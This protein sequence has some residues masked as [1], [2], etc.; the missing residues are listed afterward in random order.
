[1]VGHVVSPAT[2]GLPCYLVALPDI[3]S[4]DAVLDA[5]D[6]FEELGAP[7]F[8]ER[9]GSGLGATMTI[10]Y[11]GRSY[12]ALPVLNAAHEEL[13][14]SPLAPDQLGEH[15]A[16]DR[17]QALGFRV[18]GVSASP[19]GRRASSS[20]GST[21]KKPAATR[22][23]GSRAPSRA[24]AARVILLEW[25]VEPGEL[26]TRQELAQTFGVSKHATVDIS[27]RSRSVLAFLSPQNGLAHRTEGGAYLVTGDGRRGNQVWNSAN[28]AILNHQEKGYAL[29][30][31]EECDEKWRPGGRRVRY[32]GAFQVDPEQPWLPETAEDADRKDRTVIVF[33]LLPVE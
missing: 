12:P 5:I 4:R 8:L 22:A 20:R 19:P 23:T 15:P 7:V 29:R 28:Q 26:R 10:E 31:F 25:N 18:A 3:T 2:E 1:M 17:L 16:Q 32:V 21:A 14:G 33:R 6:S 9:Y 24:S 11:I 13:L 30:L 27:A